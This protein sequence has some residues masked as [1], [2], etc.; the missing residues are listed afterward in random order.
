MRQLQKY[1]TQMKEV[2]ELKFETLY[3]KDS[4]FDLEQPLE[5]FARNT[6][7]LISAGIFLIIAVIKD[8]I[9]SPVSRLRSWA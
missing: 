6:T 5:I 7:S 8:I 9:G 3:Q 2:L 4:Q 1:P